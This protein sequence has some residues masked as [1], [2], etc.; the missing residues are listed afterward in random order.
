M[1][2]ADRDPNSDGH[3]GPGASAE[4]LKELASIS[5]IRELLFSTVFDWS[6]T[7]LLELPSMKVTKIES[8]RPNKTSVSGSTAFTAM[9]HASMGRKHGYRDDSRRA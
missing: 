5:A 1:P 3:F 2:W 7:L 6:R 4:L 9:C 8:V